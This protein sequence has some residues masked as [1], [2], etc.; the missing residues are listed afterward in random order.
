MS[1]YAIQSYPLTVSCS[2][3]TPPQVLNILGVGDPSLEVR[4]VAVA[5]PLV[6]EVHLVGAAVHGWACCPA[7]AAFHQEV[8]ALLLGV[9]ASR[10]E[11]LLQAEEAA[12]RLVLLVAS[13]VVLATNTDASKYAVN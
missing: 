7:V 13:A 5:L 11:A 4:L 2:S 10:R 6:H 8:V 12:Y 9:A 3:I 1:V